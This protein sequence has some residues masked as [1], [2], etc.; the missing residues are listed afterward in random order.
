MLVVKPQSP[1]GLVIPCKH[2][3]L[4]HRRG[5]GGVRQNQKEE[6]MS[7]VAR[8]KIKREWTQWHCRGSDKRKRV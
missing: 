7:G 6:G 1:S 3:P 2:V 4:H 5:G 8:Q